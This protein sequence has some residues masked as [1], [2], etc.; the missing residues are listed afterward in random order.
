MS[1]EKHARA[2][3]RELA[4]RYEALL[5]LR[6]PW[7]AAWRDLAE[8]FL[9]TRFHDPLREPEGERR[10]RLLNGK[11]VDSTGILAMRTLAAGLQ[12]GMTSPARPWFRLALEDEELAQGH[13]VRAWLDEVA[14]RMRTVF[15]RSNFYNAMYSVYAELGTFG[16]AFMM[17]LGDFEHGFRF[18][19]FTAGSYVLDVNERGRVDAVFRHFQM[20]ARHLARMFG[21]TNLP[22]RLRAEAERPAGRETARHGVIHAVVPRDEV[23]HGASANGRDKTFASLYW[24][25]GSGAPWLLHEGGFE[26]FPGFGTRWEV[27]GGEVYGKSPAMDVLPDCRMLQQMGKT[28]LKAIH[29][30]V[31]PPLSVAASLKSV[32]ID[33]TPGSANYVEN[34]PGQAPQAATPILQIRPDIQAARL[35]MQDVQRQIQSGLYNDLF[36]ML[37]N[38]GRS[39]VT[40]REIA[41]REEEKL[42]LI[43]PVL[44]RL[45]DELF[46]PLIDRTFK[47]LQRLDMLPP[48]PPELA[49]QD[50]QVEFVSLLAQAQKL[51]STSAVDQLLGFAMN[52]ASAFPEA[53]DAV[54]I[55]KM[56]D[57]YADYLGVEVDMIRPLQ[58]RQRLRTARAEAQAAAQEA[59]ARR[60]AEAESLAAVDGLAQTARTLSQTSLGGQ[61]ALDALL[62]AEPTAGDEA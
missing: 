50:L 57:G 32:G 5:D 41:A 35:A 58:D 25:A 40:A 59:A 2:D 22:E 28:T 55:D 45:H 61:N 36:R 10:P 53:L 31:D 52:A 56:M 38:T 60:A 30:A 18:M 9:P 24:L 16:T 20:S 44:E 13:G 7:D 27:S 37:L 39:P 8:H 21:V 23:P 1:G 48:P 29:K 47:L 49:G 54:D 3:V 15:H 6:R 46:I 62:T 42:V 4:L 11:L 34:A 43:G 26:E 14:R 51:V 12:G 17:E 33:L 19:P